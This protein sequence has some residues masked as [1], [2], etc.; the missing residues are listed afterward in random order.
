MAKPKPLEVRV[1]VDN[2]DMIKKF[3]QAHRET[4]NF[5]NALHDLLSDIKI[6]IRVVHLKDKKWWQFWK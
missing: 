1:E 2:T 3:K 5:S 6:G 4:E